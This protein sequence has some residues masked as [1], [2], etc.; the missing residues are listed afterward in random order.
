MK[1]IM[2]K[3]FTFALSIVLCTSC[4]T[5]TGKLWDAMV[6][7]RE[8]SAATFFLLPAAVVVTPFYLFVDIV[9]LGGTDKNMTLAK[10]AASAYM[11]HKSG[12]GSFPA[13]AN[14]TNDDFAIENHGTEI[15]SDDSGT[16][17][18]T[19]YDP[20]KY[21]APR[22]DPTCADYDI[23]FAGQMLIPLTNNCSVPIAFHW[24]WVPEGAVNCTPNAV[25]NV[26]EVGQTSKIY[27]PIKGQQ[28]IAK[29]MVCDMSGE[30]RNKTCNQK[31][32]LPK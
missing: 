16:H 2:I 4:S 13:T 9:T 11:Q 27:G 8:P 23:E 19:S 17:N 20:Y 14:R 1:F 21:Y 6:T 24:C 10:G 30:N 29:F 28:R 5:N 18:Q 26:I 7:D 15:I 32:P 31:S 12:A 22:T 3:N 25:S